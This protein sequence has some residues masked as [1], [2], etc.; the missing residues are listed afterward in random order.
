[1]IDTTALNLK[2]DMFAVLDKTKFYPL[3]QSSGDSFFRKWVRNPSK[4]ETKAYGYL[5]KLTYLER[6]IESI[7]KVEFSAPK[8]IFGNNFDEIEDKDFEEI[9]IKLKQ[10]LR[11]LGVNIFEYLLN[12]APVSVIHYSKNIPLT[13]GSSPYMYLKEIQKANVTQRLDFNQTDF[14]NGHSVKF[15]VNSFEV[16]FYDKLRDLE[17]AKISEKRAIEKDNIIQMDLFE[18]IKEGKRQ[19]KTP[20]EILRMEV[21]LNQP[22]KIRQVLRKIGLEVEPTFQNLFKKEIAKRILLYHLNQIED[23]YPKLLYFKPK[24]A[25]DFIA[26]FIIDNPRAKIKDSFIA[27]GFQKA[28]D[29]LSVREIR[30][31]LKKYPKM[32]WYRFYKESNSFNYP[33][34]ALP[35]F[36]PIRNSIT[37]FKPLKLLD[38]QDEMINNDKYD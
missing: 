20:F 12:N 38:F 28:V 29:D 13:D 37:K 21:R 3:T 4:E 31:L 2:R 36:E 26:Q 11:L 30:E 22:Q 1:M 32:A 35:I 9:I 18:E 19:S 33:K 17:K 15:R 10:R 24:S 23:V 8:L 7:L 14:R 34:T 25:K 5:P 6:P 16:T 27:L